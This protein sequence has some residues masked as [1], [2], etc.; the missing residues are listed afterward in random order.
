MGLVII[1]EE[2]NNNNNN[3][4]KHGISIKSGSHGQDLYFV[5]MPSIRR[6][7]TPSVDN[8]TPDAPVPTD[9]RFFIMLGQYY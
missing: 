9:A 1:N 7:C 5:L 4:C 6:Y 2:N 3:N 8:V